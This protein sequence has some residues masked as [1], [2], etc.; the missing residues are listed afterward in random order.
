MQIH[1]SGHFQLTLHVGPGSDGM[2]LQHASMVP[3]QAYLLVSGHATDE[4]LDPD[5]LLP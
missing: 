4:V 1:V 5:V 3:S 2:Y